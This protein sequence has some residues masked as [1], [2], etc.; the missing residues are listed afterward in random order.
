MAKNEQFEEWW[1]IFEPSLQ[2]LDHVYRAIKDA[3]EKAWDNGFDC[4]WDAC[5]DTLD[6]GTNG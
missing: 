1:A 2:G 4:G 5:G 6:W 3:A